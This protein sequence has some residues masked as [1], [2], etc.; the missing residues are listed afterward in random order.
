MLGPTGVGKTELSLKIAE[1]KFE[2]ISSDSMLIYRYLDIG[3]SKPTV[4]ERKIVKHYLIDIVNPDEAFDAGNF[5]REAGTA[6][7]LIIDKGKLPLFTGGSGFYIDAFFKGLS[8]IPLVNK[9]IRKQLLVEFDMHGSEVLYDELYKYDNDFARSIHRNDKQ[10]IIR[11]LEVFRS[12]GYPI[13]SFYSNRRGFESDLTLYIGIMMEKSDLYKRI[14]KRVDLM[15]KNGFIDEVRHL[16]NIGYGPHLNSMKSIGYLELNYY[17]DGKI[18]IEDSIEK[19]K[20]STKQYAKRQM[21]WFK[22][23]KKINWVNN[24]EFEKVKNIINNW[25]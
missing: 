14:D 19:I 18:N 20:L 6:C 15:I 5:C 21:T 23:N 7:K 8:E 16:R 9:D 3:T 11:G 10:R 13:S 1:D 2:I 12:T 25:L 17:L 22:R 4:E 24:F